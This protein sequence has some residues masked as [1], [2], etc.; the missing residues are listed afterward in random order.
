MHEVRSC[1]PARGSHAA[2][3]GLKGSEGQFGACSLLSTRGGV[4]AVGAEFTRGGT[5]P[6]YLVNLAQVAELIPG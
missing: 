3:S 5:L 6:T 2:S 4:Q 1:G